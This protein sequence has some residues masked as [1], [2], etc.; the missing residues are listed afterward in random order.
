[1]TGETV[2]VGMFADHDDANRTEQINDVRR[3][4]YNIETGEN[5]RYSPYGDIEVEFD[6]AAIDTEYKR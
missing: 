2:P 3:I 4:D 6:A 1:M 5:V